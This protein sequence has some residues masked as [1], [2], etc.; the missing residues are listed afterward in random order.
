MVYPTKAVAAEAAPLVGANPTWSS[1][2]GSCVGSSV[3]SEVGATSRPTVALG[4]WVGSSVFRGG[5][6]G[7]FVGGGAA[8][9][10]PGVGAGRVLPLVEPP[11]V[12]EGSNLHRNA[13]PGSSEQKCPG[14]FRQWK[15]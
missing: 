6:V 12:Y 1:L 10:D 13:N 11:L 9:V 15:R 8:M 7:G 14:L 2:V 4:V 5:N 3:G